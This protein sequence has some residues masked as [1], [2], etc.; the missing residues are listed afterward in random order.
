[1][2]CKGIKILDRNTP[3]EQNCS[4]TTVA[5]FCKKK[6]SKFISQCVKKISVSTKMVSMS[7]VW[8][9]CIAFFSI[10]LILCQ[11]TQA[12]INHMLEILASKIICH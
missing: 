8:P 10:L 1:M 9:V 12:N 11:Q 2:I 7:V 4:Y 6:K 3:T 5:H